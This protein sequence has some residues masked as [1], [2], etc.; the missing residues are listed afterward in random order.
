MTLKT[1]IQGSIESQSEFGQDKAEQWKRWHTELAAADEAQ[2]DFLKKGDKTVKRYLS[3]DKNESFNLNLFHANTNTI[4][5]MMFGKLPEISFSRTN[6]DY[7]DD[8]ARVAGMMLQ[9]MLSADI[10]TP[11]DQYS[12][13]LRHNLEDRLVPGLGV[14]R[15]RYT[16]T[17]G[18]EVIEAVNDPNDPAVELEPEQRI[19]TITDEKAPIDYVHWRDFKWSPARVW[20]DVYMVAFRTLMTRDEL[21]KRFG[22]ELGDKI[23]LNAG[24]T[25]R[26][27]ED[28][29]DDSSKDAYS[30]AE[31]WEIWDKTNKKVVWWH[32][33]FKEI[34]DTKDDPLQLTG[35]FPNPEPMAA[36]VT[37]SGY[38][39][40]AD[41]IFAQ[42]LYNE[43]N[44]LENRIVKI[45][46]AIKVVGLYDSS[47][48]EVK[49]MLSEGTENELI[50]VSNWGKLSEA[51]GLAGVIDWLPVAELAQTLNHLVELR[52]DAKAMLY[53]ITGI[54][55]IMRGGGSAGGAVTATERSLEARFAS[56]RIQELQDQFATYATD[57]IRLRAEVVQKHFQPQ[58]IMLQSNMGNT[59]DAERAPQA[60]QL[61]KSDPS[62]IWRISVKPE[63]VSMVDYAKLQEERTGYLTAMA[64]FL[65]SSA[66]LIEM[67]PGAAPAL[68]ELLKWGLAG[69]KGSDTIEGVLDQA[70]DAMSNKK[71]EE[72]NKEPSP[73]QIKQQMEKEK[74][75]FEMQKM[76]Q[77]AEIEKRKQ[78][79]E[80]AF[81]ERQAVIRLA[82]IEA[83]LQADLQRE[84]AQAGLNMA[85]QTHET[86]AKI[87]ES[88]GTRDNSQK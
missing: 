33:E 77:A 43:I 25:D 57:L 78:Q 56:V 14:A 59:A 35:F 9:R 54:A 45:T 60:V 22:D 7:N 51:G 73:E 8:V 75:Q 70:L 20:A 76:K 80:A 11:N 65:Q 44:D 42:D 62:L 27:E 12:Q 63:S 15:V 5:A 17:E 10:G 39:P 66:P 29:G 83:E 50:P 26:E 46:E 31:I 58:T 64:T 30:K 28:T 4:K 81:M 23:P 55:D 24:K 79:G 6:T 48:E 41:F 87:R 84:K 88:R 16:F 67:E 40:V 18:E 37:T 3:Q 2:K 19:P 52:N 47:N 34:I 85:E 82:E 72:E 53:E 13:T 49:R 71:P 21:K 32:A 74:Q 69:F 68:I 61:I 36:N 38:M 86:D 1:D